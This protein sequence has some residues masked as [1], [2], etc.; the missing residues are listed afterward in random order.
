MI[1]LHQVHNDHAAVTPQDHTVVPLQDHVVTP[2]LCKAKRLGMI[3]CQLFDIDNDDT[4]DK[5]SESCRNAL[6]RLWD[7]Q[8]GRQEEEIR[9]GEVGKNAARASR[10]ENMARACGLRV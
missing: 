9:T 3:H 6:M 10:V 7:K 5:T 2:L 1:C 8:W 4:L